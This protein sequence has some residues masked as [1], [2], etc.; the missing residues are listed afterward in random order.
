MLEIIEGF[1]AEKIILEITEHDYVENY[2]DFSYALAPLRRLGVKIAIDDAGA[3]YSSMCHILNIRP[4]FIKLDISLTRNINTDRWRRALA[5]LWR[6]LGDGGE[7]GGV[8]GLVI[9]PPKPPRWSV[10]P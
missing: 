10:T 4:D 7:E 6:K 9:K 3:G 1:P 2:D 5:E 8:T